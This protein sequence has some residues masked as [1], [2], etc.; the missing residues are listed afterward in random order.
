MPAITSAHRQ[1][2]AFVGGPDNGYSLPVGARG[3]SS[4]AVPPLH[5]DTWHFGSLQHPNWCAPQSPN[6]APPQEHRPLVPPGV[7][8][9]EAAGG[10]WGRPVPP[11][12]VLFAER[13][14]RGGEG[15]AGTCLQ[16]KLEAGEMPPA[17]AVPQVLLSAWNGI[18]HTFT[19][20]SNTSPAKAR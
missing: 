5:P 7:P 17:L 19:T 13:E 3:F 9:S 18:I 16:P 14:R 12:A 20:H 15:F 1:R 4:P 11:R 6:S 10:F 2:A 8:E